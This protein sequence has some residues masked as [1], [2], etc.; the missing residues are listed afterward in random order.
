MTPLFM[1]LQLGD[2]TD[3][4]TI[5]AKAWQAYYRALQT[6]DVTVA[7]PVWPPMPA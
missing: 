6:V 5:R 2:A 1:S 7:D 4:E 3:E